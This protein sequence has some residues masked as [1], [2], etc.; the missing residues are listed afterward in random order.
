ME[1]NC[2]TIAALVQGE[3]VTEADQTAEVNRVVIDSREVQPGDFFVPLAGEHT[4]GHRFLAQAAAKGAVG[5]FVNQNAEVQLPPG[6]CVIAVPDTLQ[7][8]QQLAHKYRLQFS[9]PVVAVTGSVGKTT[10]KDL[11]AAV[12]AGR[13][14]VLKTAGNLNNEIGLPIM[15]TRLTAETEVAVLEMGMSGFGEI[16]ALAK[17]A[18]PSIGVITNIGESHLEMLGSREGIARAKC[19]LLQYLPADGVVVVNADEPLLEPYWRELDCR[20]I[21]FGFSNKA[22][23]RPAAGGKRDK[24]QLE[25]AGYPPLLVTPPLPGRH[26][27]YNLLAAVAVGRALGLD[28]EEI[29]AGLTQLQLSGMRLEITTLPTGLTVINDAYNASPTSTA[30]ALNVLVEEAGEHGKLAVL[31]DMLELGELEEEG[32]RQV[33]RLAAASQLRAL[34]VLGS[35]SRWIAQGAQEAG[36][37]ADRIVQCM[38]HAEAAEAVET[39]AQPG[40]WVLLKG[41]RGMQMEK[42]LRV[43]QRV[44]A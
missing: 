15:L 32:H 39:W 35:R 20:V 30:A 41:S 26:N 36:M 25:Q 5:C 29:T 13:Y 33:G 18:A 11:I 19:E 12:L 24:V 16:A 9:L 23:I 7:A 40:D 22:V 34:I 17:L 1:I 27:I 3:I 6:L 44:E 37:P 31:G 42:V 14:R 2:K 43:L 28:N 4:D 8:L 38:T 10:T 21:T